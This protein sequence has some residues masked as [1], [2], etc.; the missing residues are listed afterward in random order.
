[1]NKEELELAKQIE[2]ALITSGEHERF[3]QSLRARLESSG[4][5]EK[6][7]LQVEGMFFLQ[8]Y[9]KSCSSSKLTFVT[10][11]TMIT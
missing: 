3:K 5:F 2:Q 7:H 11:E 9:K 4:W 1:M 6:L 10:L 8:K